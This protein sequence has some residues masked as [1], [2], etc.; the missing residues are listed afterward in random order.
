[1]ALGAGAVWLAVMFQ[2]AVSSSPGL[3]HWGTWK[4]Y[5]F[6][7]TLAGLGIALIIAAYDFGFRQHND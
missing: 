6:I 3:F 7:A 1:M 5:A 4:D 2:R